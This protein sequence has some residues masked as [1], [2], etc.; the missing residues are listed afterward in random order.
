MD[1]GLKWSERNIA[2]VVLMLGGNARGQAAMEYLMTY[3][4]A[5]LVIAVVIAILLANFP[6]ASQGCRFDQIGFTCSQPLMDTNGTLYLK[7]TNGNSNTVIIHALNCS[8]DTSPTPPSYTE[9][10]ASQQPKLQ[11]QQTWE[12]NN[13]GTPGIPCYDALHNAL[14]PA[15]GSAFSG[16]LWIFY[17]N[18]EDGVG[19]PVRSTSAT[20]NTK[21]VQG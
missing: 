21:V 16:K 11:S 10:P 12:L 1:T 15:A 18:E 13:S 3:G 4:W 2:G 17:K 6:Q 14:K 7:L 20:V 9:L 5:L 8:T 19:Y